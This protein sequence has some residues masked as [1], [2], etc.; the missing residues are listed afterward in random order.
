MTS[1]ERTERD[2]S[3]AA[4]VPEAGEE[5]PADVEGGRRG[6]LSIRRTWIAALGAVLVLPLIVAATLSYTSGRSNGRLANATAA[7][8]VSAA[9]MEREYGVRVNLVAVTADGG[10]VDVRFTVV[11]K[12]KAGH[13]LHDSASMPDL[14]VETTGA[15]LSTR[16]PMA[17]KELTLLD[18]ATYF[19]LYP[20]SGGLIQRGTPVS[21]VID[22]IRLAPIDAQS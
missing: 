5:A 14:F 7:R 9:D 20:N 3:L 6:R 18:G 10:L 11:D 12:D 19:L 2:R 13:I 17:H 4:A 21:I 22:G 8:V 16:N 15:V 1:I